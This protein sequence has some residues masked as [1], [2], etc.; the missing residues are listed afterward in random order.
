MPVL[1]DAVFHLS[2]EETVN[3]SGGSRKR[4][5]TL[6]ST[7]PE[8]MSKKKK[9]DILERDEDDSLFF[10][11]SV[12]PDPTFN[13]SHSGGNV[14]LRLKFEFIINEVETERQLTC[15]MK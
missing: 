15:F 8:I 14:H 7:D 1:D 4:K 6:D 2:S 9:L 5:I 3:P 13:L 12:L 11:T 10:L